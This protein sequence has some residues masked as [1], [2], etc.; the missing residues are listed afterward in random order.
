MDARSDV[1]SASPGKHSDGEI[2]KYAIVSTHLYCRSAPLDTVRITELEAAVEKATRE[3]N[4]LRDAL[5]NQNRAFEQLEAFISSRADLKEKELRHFLAPRPTVSESE[6]MPPNAH[7]QST[8]SIAPIQSTVPAVRPVPTLIGGATKPVD[9]LL[10]PAQI[11]SLAGVGSST[12]IQTCSSPN[13]LLVSRADSRKPSGDVTKQQTNE[14]ED[15]SLY[16]KVPIDPSVNLVLSRLQRTQNSCNAL[17]A[18]NQ[19]ELQSFTFTQNSVQS[20]SIAL[21]SPFEVH[22]ASFTPHSYCQRVTL[23]FRLTVVSQNG[24]RIMMRIRVLEQENKELAN[25]NRTGR[26]ARLTTEIALRRRFVQDLKQT[27]SDMEYL[28]EDV[29]SEIEVFGSSLLVLQQRLSLTKL[30]AQFLAVELEKV[31]PGRARELFMKATW[32]PFDDPEFADQMVDC[33]HSEVEEACPENGFKPNQYVEPDCLITEKESLVSEPP[34]QSTSGSSSPVPLDN[35]SPNASITATDCLLSYSDHKPHSGLTRH[36][37]KRNKISLVEDAYAGS[38]IQPPTEDVHSTTSKRCRVDT[39]DF[40]L[41][42]SDVLTS[43]QSRRTAKLRPTIPVEGPQRTFTVDHATPTSC[44]ESGCSD[45]SVD[46]CSLDLSMDSSGLSDRMVHAHH[47]F[48]SPGSKNHQ[49]Q[50]QSFTV[51]NSNGPTT[52]S[53]SPPSVTNVSVVE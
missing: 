16:S 36:P 29:E 22:I 21:F 31:R 47:S 27:Y 3:R 51:E 53:H 28:I 25:G 43:S 17:V 33:V 7:Q 5:R 23:F 40:S 39:E 49:K 24:K 13:A 8:C 32:S 19:T 35:R 30:T 44:S 1:D 9:G 12:V 42:H 38:V 18:T 15:S 46:C 48:R 45:R 41:T 20:P 34:L 50:Q 26:T 4:E 52:S 10:G 11:P 37:L 14:T 2:L 6:N